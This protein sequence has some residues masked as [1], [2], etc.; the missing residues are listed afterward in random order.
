MARSAVVCILLKLVGVSIL[1]QSSW[2]EAG[3]HR[4]SRDASPA[5][6]TSDE[7]TFDSGT[8]NRLRQALK[9]YSELQARGD[10]PALPAKA[11][12]RPGAKGKDV[13][14]L[15]RRLVLTGDLSADKENGETYDKDV[16]EAVKHFQVRHGLAATGTMSPQTL[17]AMNVPV[18]RRVRQIK[19]SLERLASLDFAFP[20]R[21]VVLNIP[22]NTIEAVADGKVERRFTAVVGSRDHESPELTSAINQVVLHPAWN[23]PLSITKNEIIPK[24]RRDPRYLSRMHMHAFAGDREINPAKVDLS[25]D[26]TP[27]FSI[28]QDAG[29]WNALG[30]VKIDMPN[31]QA[32]YMHDTNNKNVFDAKYKFLSHGCA[33]VQNVR[34]LATWVLQGVPG[35]DRAALDSAIAEGEHREVKL[36]KKIPIAWVYL[37]AWVKRD[38]SVQFRDDIYGRDEDVEPGPAI[39]VSAGAAAVGAINAARSRTHRPNL[40]SR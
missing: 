1:A 10:W 31:R 21:Y 38:G 26:R 18:E 32:V 27:N 29:A 22:A 20:Q 23:L 28:R 15:R 17:A 12:F 16:V 24:M 30:A 33:R 11:K 8:A 19:G 2:A 6:V 39:M 9:T 5:A 7:P 25:A 36:Q 13:A 40:D 3:G 14:L 34:D 35:W 4:V 37:T